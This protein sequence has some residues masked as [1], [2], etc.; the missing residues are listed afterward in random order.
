[1]II[2]FCLKTKEIDY[3]DKIKY[4][5]ICFIFEIY[6]DEGFFFIIIITMKLGIFKITNRDVFSFV[7]Y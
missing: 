6:Y 3:D 7:L 5:N 1:L 2:D 4:K